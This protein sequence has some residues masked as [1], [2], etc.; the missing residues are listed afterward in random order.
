MPGEASSE[1]ECDPVLGREAGEPMASEE[2]D[3]GGHADLIS[4]AIVAEL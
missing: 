4:A 2:I 1:R 3:E